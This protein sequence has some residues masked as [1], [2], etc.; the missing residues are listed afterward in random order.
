[1][2]SPKRAMVRTGSS[3]PIAGNL[4]VG[5][6]EGEVIEVPKTEPI[7]VLIGTG[8]EVGRGEGVLAPTITCWVI[9]TEG[10][11]GWGR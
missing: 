7:E 2:E 11:K 10:V 6:G 5:V 3:P 8:V 4:G 1:M 9:A